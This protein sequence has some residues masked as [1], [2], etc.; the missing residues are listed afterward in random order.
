MVEEKKSDTQRT[1]SKRAS[2]TGK[3]LSV[4]V[5]TRYLL[6]NSRI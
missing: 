2:R 4:V 5:R 6:E 3:V 1:T